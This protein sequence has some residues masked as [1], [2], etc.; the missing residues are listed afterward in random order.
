[1]PRVAFACAFLTAL[2]VR[3]EHRQHAEVE[4]SRLVWDT[5]E[6]VF[7]IGRADGSQ[8]EAFGSVRDVAITSE[9][10][11]VVLDRIAHQ[12]K[13]ISNQGVVGP[14]IG[15]LGGGPGEFGD[16]VSVVGISPDT[17]VVFDRARGAIQV[18]TLDG[19]TLRFLSSARLPFWPN[20]ACS[21]G[22]DLYALA[23]YNERVIHEINTNGDIVRSLS[24]VRALVQ[25]QG[26][27][28]DPVLNHERG[29]G[30]LACVTDGDMIVH[31]TERLGEVHAYSARSSELLWSHYINGFRPPLRTLTAG[32]VRYDFDP[33]VGFAD[34][35]VSI[36]SL[37]AALVQIV[38]E[39]RYPRSV[40]Q[41]PRRFS[42][43]LGLGGAEQ[44][45]TSGVP[46]F[47]VATTDRAVSR[48]HQPVP[49][50]TLWRKPTS[51]Q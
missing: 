37:E 15:R 31:A 1:M 3:C 36:A 51:Q 27:G 32:G 10:V 12:L 48:I 25:S 50:L 39:T 18:F 21:I 33:N 28:A 8:G 43:F 9:E 49:R 26:V 24:S 38:V 44:A 16:P 40:S 29:G 19:E 13:P 45:R 6:P 30:W 5:W 42:I 4:S 22:G 7:E 20:D 47:V 11:L 17:V 41:Q 2:L 23:L 35:V 14:P 34:R 46:E